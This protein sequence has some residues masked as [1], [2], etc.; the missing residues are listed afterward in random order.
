[1]ASSG[2]S[3][4]VVAGAPDRELEVVE[5]GD[6]EGGDLARAARLLLAEE[7]LDE[8]VADRVRWQDRVDLVED[9]R[10]R[11]VAGVGLVLVVGPRLDDVLEL[12]ELPEL[13]VEDAREGGPC[14]LEAGLRRAPRV[15]IVRERA[16][17]GRD[18]RAV[19]GEPVARLGVERE[20]RERARGG[21]RPSGRGRSARSPPRAGPRG[22]SSGG[23]RPRPAPRR[24]PRC[25]RAPV[26][27]RRASRTGFLSRTTSLVP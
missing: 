8:G 22:G 2:A 10:P 24:R 4:A 11:E 25:R 23:S 1:M 15:G 13:H 16:A 17:V 20:P 26:G 7:P 9:G 3:R 14:Q 5:A 12:R 6:L 18:R 19:L 21:P 27:L